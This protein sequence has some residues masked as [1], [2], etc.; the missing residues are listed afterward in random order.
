[1]NKTPAGRNGGA[2]G[3]KTI[4]C[5]LFAERNGQYLRQ[6]N[7]LQLVKSNATPAGWHDGAARA[8]KHTLALWRET[9]RQTLCGKL[10][11][12]GGQRWAKHLLV[13]M[14]DLHRSDLLQ[15]ATVLTPNQF[16]AEQLTGRRIR[17]EQDALQA[18]SALLERGPKTVVSHQPR[19][20][21]AAVYI[22]MKL[23]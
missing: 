13:D 1:M 14:V 6:A 10:L 3:W 7:A 21:S 20:T 16:E 12:C 9:K 15:L 11:H 2:P 19:R 5:I 18:C 22:K 17:T 4:H 23:K 8:G